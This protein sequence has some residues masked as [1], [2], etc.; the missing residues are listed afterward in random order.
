MLLG[1]DSDEQSECS[2]IELAGF[3]VEHSCLNKSYVT[4]ASLLHAFEVFT[5]FNLSKVLHSTSHGTTELIEQHGDTRRSG[6]SFTTRA[7]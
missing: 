2:H 3:H 1:K 5:L 7:V 4:I 6:A